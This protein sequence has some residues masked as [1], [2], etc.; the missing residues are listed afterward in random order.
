MCWSNTEKQY[1]DFLGI[2]L[3]NN[4]TENNPVPVLEDSFG[5]KRWTAQAIA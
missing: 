5:D 1:G 2:H 4:S 3:A